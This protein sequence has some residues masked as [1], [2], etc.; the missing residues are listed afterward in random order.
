MQKSTFNYELIP[1]YSQSLQNY[2]YAKA[3]NHNNTYLLTSDEQRIKLFQFSKNGLKLMQI[4]N[5]HQSLVYTLNFMKGRQQFV[6]GSLDSS[7]VIWSEI[8]ISNP[9]Y[10]IKLNQHQDSVR[11]L[12]YSS[13]F[14]NLI[15]SGS[16]DHTIK[17]WYHFSSCSS[18]SCQQTINEH[19]DA[20]Y[21]LSMNEAGTTLISC[22]SDKHILVMNRENSN[23]KYWN[24][25]QKISVKK[26]GLRICFITS[27]MFI[28]L[29][30][31]N[32]EQWKGG[33][34]LH[35]YTLNKDNSKFRKREEYIIKGGGQFCD[36]E[37]PAL[38][39]QSKQILLL[40]NG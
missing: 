8:S 1:E 33:K 36:A 11:C 28:F 38:F 4:L 20:V 21:G 10:L 9:K 7:I 16:D 17:F 6:S 30:N 18:W 25:I 14:K 24:V 29:P 13:H 39:V 5:K 34:A 23:L 31:N 15:V 27:K 37:F 12:H 26:W 35:I 32:G 40:K 22:S 3:I 19:D 2:C